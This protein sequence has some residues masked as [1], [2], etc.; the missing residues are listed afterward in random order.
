MTRITHPECASSALVPPI[1]DSKAVS[2]KTNSEHK[3]FLQHY[4]SRAIGMILFFVL[5]A[6]TFHEQGKADIFWIVLGFNALI[7]PHIG[8]LIGRLS[9]R[10]MKVEEYL[11]YL[12]SLL[13][14]FYVCSIS[15]SL[16]P[17]VATIGGN[18]VS[19]LSGGNIRMGLKGIALTLLGTLGTGLIIGFNFKPESGLATS[20]VSI[21]FVL[22]YIAITSNFAYQVLLKLSRS[23]KELAYANREVNRINKVTYLVN[24]TLNLD[25]VMQSV[26]ESLQGIVSFNQVGI[27]L[28]NKDGDCLEFG[29]AYGDISQSQVE[30]WAQQTIPLDHSSSWFVKAAVQKTP[31][32]IGHIGSKE[33]ELFDAYDRRLYDVNPVRGVLIFPLEV[34]GESIG[35]IM[36]GD[37]RNSLELDEDDILRIQRYITQIATAINNAR[38]Y[39]ELQTMQETL[40]SQ[41]HDLEQSRKIIRRYLPSAVVESIIEGR[42]DTVD[43]PQR[44]RLTI[45]FSDIVGFTDMADRMDAE[46]TTQVINEYM[47][48][49]S[50]IVE[51]HGGTLTE[52]AGDGLMALFGAPN[53]MAPEDQVEH[54]V[55]A[56]LETQSRIPELNEGWF[57]LGIGNPLKI[58]IGINTGVLSVG[59]F[60][61]EGRMTYTAIGLQAN[62]AARLEAHCDPGGVLISEDSW[63]LVK[64]RI[65]C[66]PM[67]EVECKGVHYPV[68]VYAP[69]NGTTPQD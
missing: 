54:A 16:W 20:F 53:E 27:A 48:A 58:R 34:Q 41:R 61:S 65:Q 33:L 23:R 49:M 43:K 37:T 51:S 67:G 38:L 4:L 18:T 52:F 35:S 59:S 45:F 60:G 50:Q 29:R 25:D 42:H 46:S 36:L 30:K 47:S 13:A 1:M 9:S 11:M 56:A 2:R 28:I 39:Q 7:W 15:F 24:S 31:L 19:N 5:M 68:K 21:F 69:V 10:P 8:Y 32:Y 63:H 22:S 40:E 44:R 6:L 12:D 14:G 57:R 62:V 3:T 17:S 26:I 64:D 55:R 66:E